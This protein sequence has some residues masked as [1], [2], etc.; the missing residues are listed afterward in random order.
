M[1]IPSSTFNR[2]KNFCWIEFSFFIDMVMRINLLDFSI[3]S[4]RD[5]I[6]I[7]IHN[8]SS[9]NVLDENSRF[10][11]NY[12]LVSLKISPLNKIFSKM[13]S[14]CSIPRNLDQ[15]EFL[16]YFDQY[17]NVLRDLN[18]ILE[19]EEITYHTL[20]FEKVFGLTWQ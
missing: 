1:Y 20:K 11:L 2:V 13:I 7:Y 17:S 10:P 16:R 15:E 18:N 12:S 3:K 4:D 19:S 14:L 9:R 5:L 8:T 6:L